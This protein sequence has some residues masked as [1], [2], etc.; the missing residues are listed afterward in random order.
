MEGIGAATALTYAKAGAFVAINYSSDAKPAEALVAQ[1]GAD[2]A[3]AI[4]GNA[5]SVADIEEVVAATVKRFGK[6]D[7]LLPNAG[8]LDKKTLEATT[9]EAF[10]FSYSL[11]VKGPFFLC[12]KAL[13]HMGKGS[14]IIL[15]STGQCKASTVTAEYLLYVSTKGAIEQM[16]RVMA[17]DL[18]RRGINV[19]AIAPGPT[20]T[21]LF[22]AGLPE[23]AVKM[24]SGLSPFNKIG[25]VQEIA[26]MMLVL[27]SQASRWVAGQIYYVNG[28][29]AV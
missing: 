26:D 8:I 22:L 1:I 15:V 3:I 24:V 25:E 7:I 2:K 19:N 29:S 12:Q 21:D 16:T 6:I 14:H 9:E 13:P 10:D 4:K 17:K 23:Q 5:G 27:A 18:G 20:G 11:N 28:A